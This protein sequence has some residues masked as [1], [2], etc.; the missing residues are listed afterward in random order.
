MSITSRIKTA[1]NGPN[2]QRIRPLIS[3]RRDEAVQVVRIDAGRRLAQRLMELGLTPG[4][5][6][7]VVHVNGGPML[8]A[9]RGARL[10]IGRG[11]AEKILVKT[12][13]D[14]DA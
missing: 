9:V 4:T 3:A 13:E 2:R 5:V 10:A 14:E 8:I 7:H 1:P 11:M 12:P 6:V